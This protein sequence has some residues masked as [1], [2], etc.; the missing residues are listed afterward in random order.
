MF[1]LLSR[2]KDF[3][4]RYHERRVV[5]L[6]TS[7]YDLRLL[8]KAKKSYL[9]RWYQLSHISKVLNPKER[10]FLR[11][12]IIILVFSIAWVGLRFLFSFRTEVPKNGGTYVEAVVG[13]PQFV[14]PIFAQTND[15][16]LDITRL[17]FSGLLRY[18]SEHRLIPDLAS[19]YEV[20]ADK[21]VYTFSL[22]QDVVW[23]D[24]ELFT[25]SDVVYT[26]ETIQNS[27]VA[28]PLIVT[29]Q[30]V[31]AEAVDDY[32][33]KFTLQEPFA[34]FLGAMT[35]GILPEHIWFDVLPEQM[36]LAKSNLQPIGTGPFKFKK[37]T[38]DDVG[39]IYRYEL[40]RFAR[41][42]RRPSY[43]DSFDFVFYPEY[44]GDNGAVKAFRE[45]KALGLN[46]VPQAWRD[47]VERKNVVLH[48]VN[49]PQYSALFFNQNHQ[50][51]LK[52]KDVR[53][54][55]ASAIDKEQILRT[56][57]KNEGQILSGPILPG[58]PGYS[59][60]LKAVS[61][62]FSAANDLLDKSWTR[63]GGEE[64]Q[65][66]KLEALMKDWDEQNKGVIQ[67]T[68]TTSTANNT[69]TTPREAAEQE[70]KN[71]LTN[72][73]Q[74][75]QT[76][77]RKN[78]AGE[79]LEIN[80]V[81]ADT[82]EYHQAAELIAGFWENVG[83]KTNLHFVDTKGFSR[84]V[85][86]DRSYDVLLYG[87]IV[88]ADPDPYPFWHSSQTD[89]PGLNLSQYVNRSVDTVIDKIR[90]GVGEKE[91]IELYRKFQEL[92]VADL[93]AV[94][95]YMPSYT[96]ATND[97]VRGINVKLISHPS[98]RLSEASDWYMKTGGKWKF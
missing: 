84:D 82:K 6:R 96:F 3:Y 98:D 97:N 68:S 32:T 2:V 36:R 79:W 39:R 31:Q 48:S 20:S 65:K 1:N 26:I 42:Y 18:D 88:G 11:V 69:T 61:F 38:K 34:S 21:K 87:E 14:N 46:F 73:M 51:I 92:V 80:L 45:Q 93:P 19:K 41:F 62:S 43:L 53:T 30:G 78:K 74:S 85:L 90:G 7:N 81:T 91:T 58:F 28:S 9:P 60:D 44:D 64:Y 35:V 4:R 57:L 27:T 37:L 8:Q 25:A 49:L 63:V 77:Y 22:R 75:G 83:V 23:H 55:M 29:F 71:Q 50:P 56:V 86:K 33:V 72:E 67:A 16:D 13:S 70:F 95:L 76:F 59:A 17:V 52:G 54:A 89:Y 10:W 12:S 24:E 5:P 47:S 15:V 40:E 94:F 66:V